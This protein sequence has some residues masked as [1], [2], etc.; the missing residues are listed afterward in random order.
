LSLESALL[1]SRPAAIDRA[2]CNDYR[3]GRA[4]TSKTKQIENKQRIFNY[5]NLFYRGYKPR[6]QRTIA[7][8]H[9]ALPHSFRAVGAPYL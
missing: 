8:Q 9:A 7:V 1:D 3:N 5:L 6:L 4:S 2:L